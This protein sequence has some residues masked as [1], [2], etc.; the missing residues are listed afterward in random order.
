MRLYGPTIEELGANQRHYTS[1]PTRLGDVPGMKFQAYRLAN[2]L[3]AVLSYPDPADKIKTTRNYKSQWD[4][5]KQRLASDWTEAQLSKA[6]KA[7]EETGVL[8][9]EENGDWFL[10][11][12]VIPTTT[13]KKRETEVKETS[14]NIP[15]PED[16]VVDVVS[17][18]KPP[19]AAPQKVMN[20]GTQELIKTT[21]VSPLDR[22]Y[23]DKFLPLMRKA[24]NNGTIG[25]AVTWME[26]IGDPN[27]WLERVTPEENAEPIPAT[28]TANFSSLFSTE[29]TPDIEE[30]EEE[31]E[32]KGQ[33]W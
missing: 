7:L 3:F 12:T 2:D 31:P 1:A 13:Y 4:F 22:L 30:P 14:E 18:S 20:P 17:T 10:D 24:Y 19:V 9:V 11:I 28:V 27:G 16:A 15:S 21:P 33:Q 23:H 32:Q 8:V 26:F 6:K 25:H 29:F 5:A